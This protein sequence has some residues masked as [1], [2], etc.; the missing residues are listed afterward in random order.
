MTL[1]K[2]ICAHYE[3]WNNKEEVTVFDISWEHLYQVIQMFSPVCTCPQMTAEV[4]QMEFP[5]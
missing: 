5:L 4:P 1:N 3:G 2:H